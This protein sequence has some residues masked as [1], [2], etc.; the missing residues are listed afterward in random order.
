[1]LVSYRLRTVST[2]RR[3]MQCRTGAN[4]AVIVVMGRACCEADLAS[5]QLK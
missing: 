3:R 2:V 4:N 1:M 5:A